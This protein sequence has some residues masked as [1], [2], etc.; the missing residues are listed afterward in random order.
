[1]QVHQL[2]LQRKSSIS[3]KS[4]HQVV[5][6]TQANQVEAK[7]CRN[8]DSEINKYIVLETVSKMFGGTEVN[9]F[10]STKGS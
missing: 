1:M 3:G 9:I 8:A 5:R 4:V 10:E 7:T 2:A 6:Q